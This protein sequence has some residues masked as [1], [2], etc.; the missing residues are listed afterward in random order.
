MCLNAF[1]ANPMQKLT[2][3][4]IMV[5][6]LCHLQTLLGTCKRVY[7][8]FLELFFIGSICNS[9]WNSAQVQ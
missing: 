9:L 2:M 8:C 4:E 7:K 6:G 5:I 3:G 1:N